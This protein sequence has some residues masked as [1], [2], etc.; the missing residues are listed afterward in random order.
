MRH[1]LFVC[2]GCVTIAA[3]T[4]SLSLQALQAPAT[5]QA[6]SLA[7]SHAAAE[8]HLEKAVQ[9]PVAGDPP[10]SETNFS[11]ILYYS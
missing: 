11:P 6:K 9:N 1:S 2:T 10:G 5:S 3:L 7:A 8:A 4:V